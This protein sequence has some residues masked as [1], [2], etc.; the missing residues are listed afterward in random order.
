MTEMACSALHDLGAWDEEAAL[1]HDTLAR[2]HES[3]ERRAA[4]IHQ[5]GMLAQ[6]RGD[7]PEAEQR[8]QQSLQINERL[9]NHAGIAS[10]YHQL[11]ILA[12]LRGDHPEAEQRYQQSLQTDERLGNQADIATSLSQLGSLGA[13]RGDVAGAVGLHGRALAIRAELGLRQMGIDVRHLGEHRA[14]LGE[15]AFRQALIAGI[16]ADGATEM[17]AALDDLAR[18]Q[19]EGDDPGAAAAG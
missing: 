19:A 8:H 11:G 13:A 6:D 14:A 4:W 3:S 2:L 10:S 1:I 16:G 5:L 17:I 15:D 18:R 12:Q 9:G 7:Y